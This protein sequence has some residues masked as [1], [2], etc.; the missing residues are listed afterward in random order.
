MI[1]KMKFGFVLLSVVACTVAIYCLIF[2]DYSTLFYVNVAVACITEIVLLSNIPIFSDKKFMTFKN[3]AVSMTLN[4]SVIILFLWTVVYSLV[5]DGTGY[6]ALYIGIL[7][8]MI[9]AIVLFG[10]TE[11][12]GKMMEKGEKE[13]IAKLDKK[14]KF[15]AGLN[16]FNLE[17]QDLLSSADVAWKDE[18]M[19]TLNMIL[20]KITVIPTEKLE[21]N[22]DLIEEFNDKI[23]GIKKVAEQLSDASDTEKTKKQLKK[24]IEALKNYIVMIKS[25]L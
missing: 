10:A 19:R 11:L 4:V 24:E 14:K 5:D 8:I 18:T 3:A 7:V 2:D 1:S 22:E 13:S 15:V 25:S 20:E 17:M 21:N 23:K 6:T 12:G 9:I 16:L